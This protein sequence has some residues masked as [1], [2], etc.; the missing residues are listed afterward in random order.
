MIGEDVLGGGEAGSVGG[1]VSLPLI[2]LNGSGVVVGGVATIDVLLANTFLL[3]GMGS[4]EDSVLPNESLAPLPLLLDR[5]LV[6]AESGE[7]LPWV[8]AFWPGRV[9]GVRL[10]KV[11]GAV[12]GRESGRGCCLA[13]GSGE[14]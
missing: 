8:V 10:R 14:G 6:R 7:E 4:G 12:G 1:G 11:R 3:A 2:V 9:M 5:E 13:G